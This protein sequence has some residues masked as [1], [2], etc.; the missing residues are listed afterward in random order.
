[1]NSLFQPNAKLPPMDNRLLALGW[2]IVF[3]LVTSFLPVPLLPRPI[4]VLT[5]WKELLGHGLLHELL[6]S[7]RLNVEAI[8]FTTALSLVLVYASLMPIVRPF[9]IFISKNR[10]I[11]F[12]GLTVFFTLATSGVHQFKLALLVYGMLV[13]FVTSMLSQLDCIPMEQYDHARTLGMSKWRIVW[14]VVVRGKADTVIDVM[15]E[16]AA[17]GW[18]LL[19][20]VEGVARAEGGIGVMLLNYN[21]Y[22]RLD[23]VFALI[24]TILIVVLAQDWFLR[25]CKSL[26]FPYST[27]DTESK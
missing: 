19:P 21:K 1:M 18:M 23:A 16:N 25:L 7:F 10:A 24:L 22:L 11:G 26:L 9:V 3:L 8:A 27:L 17:M 13:W 15:R 6:V 2:V 12:V 4:A 5:A 14:E 20:M